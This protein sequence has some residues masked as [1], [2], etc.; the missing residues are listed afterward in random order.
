LAEESKASLVKRQ[1]NADRFDG[2]VWCI[3]N[4]FTK[5]ST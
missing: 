1:D 5:A 2:E 4:V 3:M